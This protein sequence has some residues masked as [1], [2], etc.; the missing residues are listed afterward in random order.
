MTRDCVSD[1]LVTFPPPICDEGRNLAGADSSN[2]FASP[3]ALQPLFGCGQ[4][5]IELDQPPHVIAQ[6]L[7]LLVGP[8]TQPLVQVVR[9]V[10][11]LNS[12]HSLILACF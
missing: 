10:L 4:R 8:L 9:N 2:G 11:D 5:K 12:A 7:P 3:D 1:L 6:A